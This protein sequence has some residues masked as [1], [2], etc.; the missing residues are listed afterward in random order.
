MLDNTRLARLFP[1]T[2]C[3]QKIFLNKKNIAKIQNERK[4]KI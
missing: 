1:R 4:D 3:T 2:L